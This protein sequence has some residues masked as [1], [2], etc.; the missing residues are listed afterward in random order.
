MRKLSVVGVK[1]DTD[2]EHHEMIGQS[3][4]CAM[5]CRLHY[6][7]FSIKTSEFYL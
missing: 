2:T 4:P 5:L 3:H 6:N 1:Y 7:F